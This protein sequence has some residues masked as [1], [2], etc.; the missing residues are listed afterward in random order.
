M[1]LGEGT[2]LVAIARSAEDTSENGIETAAG[3]DAELID[4]VTDESP[5]ESNADADQGVITSTPEDSD[6]EP[7]T[8][9]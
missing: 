6:D 5:A 3:V 2:T 9:S 7:P 8:E 1:N 4:G